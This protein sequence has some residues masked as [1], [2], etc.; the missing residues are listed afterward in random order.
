M[1]WS[2]SRM[3]RF[4]IC[5]VLAASAVLAG[6]GG[7]G[8]DAAAPVQIGG[9]SGAEL[10]DVQVLHLGNGTEIQTLDPQIGQEVQGANVMRDVFEGLVGEAANG[11][12]VPGA[13][14]SWT[15]TPDGKQYV[16]ALR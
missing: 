10:A 8:G 3:K 16:F 1:K 7:S 2:D 12:L 11:D 6:C 5:A 13:A 9:A 15:M 4:G 14:E